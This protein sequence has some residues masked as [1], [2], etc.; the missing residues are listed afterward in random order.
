MTEGT[1]RFLL[2]LTRRSDDELEGPTTLPGWSGKHLVAHVAANADALLNLAH[3]AGTGD[4]TPMYS[5][6]AQRNAD[7][8]AGARLSP[9]ELRSWVQSSADRLGSCLTTLTEEQ[10][11][12]T[13]RTAQGRRVPATE[14]PWMRAREVMVHAVDLDPG[15]AFDDL[16]QEFLLALIDDVVARRSGAD[17]PSLA[18]SADGSRRTW[19]VTGSG[20]TTDIHGPLGAIAAYLT[21]RPEADVTAPSGVVPDLPPWL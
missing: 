4:E 13:V 12:R 6:P 1:E 5:S 11:S 14:I 18:L 3:W 21:G 19:L 9:V 10:W 7:I 16:P 15:T 2:A 20:G 8:Q 17:Q